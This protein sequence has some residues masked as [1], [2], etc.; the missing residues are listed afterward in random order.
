MRGQIL[1]RL[2]SFRQRVD[3]ALGSSA[4]TSGG[5]PHK[6]WLNNT[7]RFIEDVEVEWR[8]RRSTAATPDVLT[9][10]ATKEPEMVEGLRAY[11]VLLSWFSSLESSMLADDYLHKYVVQLRMPIP[12]WNVNNAHVRLASPTADGWR[13]R[14]S[15]IG[16]LEESRVPNKVTEVSTT[17]VDE[18]DGAEADAAETESWFKV[19]LLQADAVYSMGGELDFKPPGR[20]GENRHQTE[21]AWRFRRID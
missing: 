14:V 4:E 1:G 8:R 16:A 5:D 9:L 20:D 12:A 11:R 13:F 21:H 6:Q 3:S 19:E 15:V 2:H 10:L 7:N 17:A 18:R